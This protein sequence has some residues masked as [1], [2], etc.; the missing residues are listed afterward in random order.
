MNKGAVALKGTANHDKVRGRKNVILLGDSPGDLRMAGA[1]SRSHTQARP[2]EHV[3]AYGGMQ[4]GTWV[5]L[6]SV[7]LLCRMPSRHKPR[8]LPQ[9]ALGA[10]LATLRLQS[11]AAHSVCPCVFPFW[12]GG[13]L[14]TVGCAGGADGLDDAE[15]V[16]RIGFLNDKLV[17]RRDEYLVRETP[18]TP[19]TEDRLPASPSQMKLQ[20]H[21]GLRG[22]LRTHT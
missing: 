12:R 17:E 1:C 6:L 22:L 7:L 19:K 11:C 13:S 8:P 18:K 3:S 9:E 15:T 20:K 4:A 2:H 16:L 14:R 5:F 10:P 21:R